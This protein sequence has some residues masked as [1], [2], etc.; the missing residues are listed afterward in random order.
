MRTAVCSGS[1]D[2]I[3]LGPLDVIRRTAAC[4]LK[5]DLVACIASDAHG[6]HR[7]SN[8]LLEVVDHL[9]VHYHKQYAQC[10]MYENPLRILRDEAI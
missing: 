4:L 9:T 10:L 6:I 7:R 1:F 3:T 8:F 2:P 5:N